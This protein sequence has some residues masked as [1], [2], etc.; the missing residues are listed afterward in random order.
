MTFAQPSIH[1]LRLR[2]DEPVTTMTDLVVAAVCFAGFLTLNRIAIRNRVHRYLRYY[3]LSMA[4][5][6]LLSGV[7]G[8]AFLYLFRYEPAV[9]SRLSR[10]VGRIVGNGRILVAESPWKLPGW[11]T[12]MFSV[13]LVERASIEY[14]RPLVPDGV[15]RAFGW[16][17]LLK[18]TGFGTVTLATLN[19]LF[20]GVHAFSGLV[21][22][23]L[24][25]NVYIFLRTRSA[26][27][28]YFMAAVGSAAAA[29]LLF[30]NRWAPHV[31]FNH[32]DVSHI[33]IAF[34]AWLFLKG[35]LAAIEED[36]A[37]RAGLQ[38]P[39]TCSTSSVRV[40][41]TTISRNRGR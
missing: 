19:F 18:L 32:L 2:I 15:T 21:L 17:N 26:A 30:F 22:G 16:F 4:I 34:S 8:H 41:R 20:V 14:A 10:I 35:A 13:A 7:V 28:R 36:C 29:A 23:V 11:L 25:L 1:L 31:W 12:S 38:F 39:A 9:T 33:L 37:R 5:A 40:N 6:A 3:F 24:S 27:S